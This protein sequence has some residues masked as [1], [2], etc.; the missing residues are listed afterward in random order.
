MGENGA[1]NGYSGTGKHHAPSHLSPQ[2]IWSSQIPFFFVMYGYTKG[3]RT[4]SFQHQPQIHRR[5]VSLIIITAT[6]INFSQTQFLAPFSRATFLEEKEGK[7]RMKKRR[8][9]KRKM[10]REDVVCWRRKR[11]KILLEKKQRK[12]RK[13]SLKKQTKVPPI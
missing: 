1:E 6:T 8:R 7:K 9:E 4:I 2:M 3:K 13:H 5:H 11:K 10:V 12:T